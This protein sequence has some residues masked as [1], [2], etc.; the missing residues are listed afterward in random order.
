MKDNS[1]LIFLGLLGLLGILF[2]ADTC[3]KQ[4]ADAAA[5]KANVE[6]EKRKILAAISKISEKHNAADGWEA[7]LCKGEDYRHTPIL[8]IELE[9]LWQSGRPIL[10][11]GTIKDISS[12]SSDTYRV[13]LEKSPYDLKYMFVTDLRLSL[14]IRKGTMDSFLKQNPNLQSDDDLSNGVAVIAGIDSI[15]AS[16]EADGGGSRKEVR[17]GQGRLIEIVFAGDL[18]FF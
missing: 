10:F 15:V 17:T 13:V 9:R 7:A 12:A 5:Q 3:D 18:L 8:T 16:D 4:K 14:T 2:I 1:V 11:I 6:R